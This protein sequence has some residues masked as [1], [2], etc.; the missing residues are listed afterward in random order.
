MALFQTIVTHS[1]PF[2]ADDVLAV[3]VLSDLE[4][5]ARVIRTRD[6][7]LL[8]AARLDSATVLVD[9]G[10]S[11][12]VALRNFDHHQQ[13]FRAQRPN[14]VPF[15]SIGL[16]WAVFGERWL[17]EIMELDDASE[18]SKVFASVDEDLIASVDAFDCGA[19]EGTHRIRHNGTELRV[20]SVA[21]V[22]GSFNPTWFETPDFD[23]RF[24][25][26]V[27]VASGLLRR[28]AWRAVGEVRYEAV[29]DAED[30]GQPVLM[31]PTAG[32]WRRYVKPHHLVVV[33]PAVGEEGWLAQ[34][35][36]DPTSTSFPPPLR[37]T[38]PAA[39]RGLS[40]EALAELTGIESTTFCHR[41]G[42][43]AGATTR[44]GARRLAALLV[45]HGERPDPSTL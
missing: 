25:D 11:Y 28:Q 15:A 19:V 33:F 9:V 45:A 10:W 12:D 42:F 31:L 16:V 29:V 39:W 26:A 36:G 32:P 41:A 13:S 35:V 37:I 43:I 4:P 1:G 7:A 5:S 40:P 34:A 2:H 3:A 23:M 14:G 21:D 24:H 27:R 6:S 17:Q 38:Y 30:D 22:I 44:E 8:E 18:R 20:P